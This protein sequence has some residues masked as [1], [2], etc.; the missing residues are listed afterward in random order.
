MP[1]KYAIEIVKGDQIIP[2]PE[3]SNHSSQKIRE[4]QWDLMHG[5]MTPDA[6][7]VGQI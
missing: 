6:Q 5:R 4:A 1:R 3:S 7:E 2:M